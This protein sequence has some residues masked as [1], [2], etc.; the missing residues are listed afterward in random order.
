M[1]YTTESSTGPTT[2]PHDRSPVV[3]QRQ[4]SPPV[5]RAHCNT[6]PTA[7]VPAS[8]TGSA[9]L[10]GT[11]LWSRQTLTSPTQSLFSDGFA[12]VA[13][14]LLLSRSIRDTTVHRTEGGFS[15]SASNYAPSGD[16]TD[17]GHIAASPADIPELLICDAGGAGNLSGR[18]ATTSSPRLAS[19]SASSPACSAEGRTVMNFE[20]LWNSIDR[21]LFAVYTTLQTGDESS[22]RP[23]RTPRHRMG[24]YTV[25]Y[26]ACSG[27]P[28]KSRELYA[29]LA[30]L[31]LH[32]LESHVLF[33]IL[34]N[35]DHGRIHVL[36]GTEDN[37]VATTSTFAEDVVDASLRLS[38]SWNGSST[39]QQSVQAPQ[40]GSGSGSGGSFSGWNRLRN[41]AAGTSSSGGGGGRGGAF[42]G[43]HP[44]V[45][46]S[47]DTSRNS[48][49]HGSA[50]GR[51]TT[52]VVPHTSA[53]NSSFGFM[54]R[55]FQPSHRAT[56]PVASAHNDNDVS[57]DGRIREVGHQSSSPGLPLTS[58]SLSVA[59][60]PPRGRAGWSS[61]SA[62]STPLQLQT[63]ASSDSAG[64]FTA[65]QSR[66]TATANELRSAFEG[67]D[68][69]VCRSSGSSSATASGSAATMRM[70]L[71]INTDLSSSTPVEVEEMPL[72]Q[73]RPIPQSLLSPK[74]TTRSV[75]HTASGTSSTFSQSPATDP[76]VT[77]VT[78][79]TSAAAATHHARVASKTGRVLVNDEEEV[80]C[81][82]NTV[83]S[84]VRHSRRAQQP[85]SK[86]PPAAAPA[87][88][89]TAV[90]GESEKAV[91]RSPPPLPS[92]D[93]STFTHHSSSNDED[94]S[95]HTM[96]SS[97][98]SP[99]HS[100]DDDDAGGDSS[101]SAQTSSGPTMI[102]REQRRA[103]RTVGRRSPPPPHRRGVVS[104]AVDD[105]TEDSTAVPSANLVSSPSTS[106]TS[107]EDIG[108]PFLSMSP[109]I[110][111]SPATTGA[112]EHKNAVATSITTAPPDPSL[113]LSESAPAADEETRML[114]RILHSAHAVNSLPMKRVGSASAVA[115]PTA[116]PVDSAS[117][118]SLQPSLSRHTSS[119]VPGSCFTGRETAVPRTS[120]TTMQDLDSPQ[121]SPL[122]YG[123]RGYSGGHCAGDK[124][125]ATSD[126]A[127][128]SIHVNRRFSLCYTFIQEWETFLVF[129]GVV[130][131]CFR[132]LDQYYTRRYGMDTITLMCFKVFYV[133]VYEPLRPLLALE[134]R[135]LTRYVRE[136][137]ETTRQIAWEQL[138]LIQTTYNIMAELLVLV[139]STSSYMVSQKQQK[140]GSGGVGGATVTNTA[141]SAAA[142]AA[143]SQQALHSAAEPPRSRTNSRGRGLISGSGG[144]V[145]SS[146]SSVAST[147]RLGPFEAAMGVSSSTAP[148]TPA[149]GSHAAGTE[150]Q[151]ATTHTPSRRH[152]LL[153]LFTSKRHSD[154]PVSAKEE[155]RA[156]PQQQQQQQQ[157]K[158][159]GSRRGAGI[160]PSAFA[161][162]RP[163][164]S[165]M[166]PLGGQGSGGGAGVDGNNSHCNSSI[167]NARLPTTD[168]A[169]D[170]GRVD[171][172]S[173]AM[174]SPVLAGSSPGS[175]IMP[176]TVVVDL[177][178]AVELRD[179]LEGHTTA[180]HL[181]TQALKQWEGLAADRRLRNGTIV[182][183]TAQ[184]LA[185][186]VMEDMGND[187]VAGVYSFYRCA[188]EAHRD[189][190][191]GRRC[192]VEWALGVKELE[193]HVWRRVRLP[194][195]HMAIRSAL[196]EVLVV[197]QHRSILLDH[198][199]GLGTLL[200]EWSASVKNDDL[201]L[202][203]QPSML[204]GAASAVAAVWRGTGGDTSAAA[205]PMLL[206]RNRGSGNPVPSASPPASLSLSKAA[207]EF[208]EDPIQ[209]GLHNA[210]RHFVSCF[211][212]SR[213][214]TSASF[215][216]LS[217][218][219]SSQ[220]MLTTGG[221]SGDTTT[222]QHQ[223][224]SRR[225]ERASGASVVINPTTAAASAA[226]TTL[227][228]LSRVGACGGAGETSESEDTSAGVPATTAGTAAT[229]IAASQ[230]RDLVVRETTR[231]RAVGGGD[232]QAQP[233][234]RHDSAMTPNTAQL[235]AGPVVPT[236]H[237]AVEALQ[238]LYSL[239]SDVTEDE[240]FV[241]MASILITNFIRAA[242]DSFE[243]YL[244]KTTATMAVDEPGSSS[245]REAAATSSPPASS[246]SRPPNGPA[247]PAA[248]TLAGS[249]V[250]LM[251]DLI[252]LIDRY[253][254]LVETAFRSQPILLRALGDA[255]EELMCPTRWTKKGSL[256]AAQQRA[257]EMLMAA[258]AAAAVNS[259][260]NVGAATAA[261]AAA[262]SSKSDL[263]SV[264]LSRD[265][266]YATLPLVS[267]ATR[268]PQAVHQL[269]LSVLLAR[270]AD[271]FLQ[272]ERVGGR[273][274]NG[275]IFKRL[276][277]IG[278]LVSLLEDKDTFLEHYRLCLA[279]RLLGTSGSVAPGHEAGSPTTSGGGVGSGSGGGLLN[280]EA[281][282]QL[283]GCLQSYLGAT[284]TH[285]FEAML[286][287]YEGTQRTRE[288]FEQEPTFEAL[289]AKI[290]VQLITSAQWPMYTMLPL[291][292]HSS[293]QIGM[294]AFRGY[295][296]RVHPSRTLL[297]VFSLGTAT[298][299]AE[300]VSGTKQVVAST[301][302][303]TLLLVVSDAYNARAGHAGSITGSQIA[304]KVGMPFHALRTHLHLLSQH[305]AFNLL[306]WTPV[307][308]TSVVDAA[309][310]AGSSAVTMTENDR[311]TLNPAYTHKLRK[312][313]L[314]LPKTRL[315]G[316]PSSEAQ[317]DHAMSSM[318]DGAD[319]TAVP[320]SEDVV[321]SRHVHASRRQLL[322]T[323]LV[324]VFKSRRVVLFED[325]FQA[326]TMQL[327]RQF[328]PTRRDVKA[329]LEGLI[330]RDYVKRSADD[331]NAFVYVS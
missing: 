78:A 229:R 23:L 322:D 330:D 73:D 162:R 48:S 101:R 34:Q 326:V 105:D 4:R 174:S 287:D 58:V 5:C 289:V 125:A 129:R 182:K 252:L 52:A 143:L 234:P 187:Y 202:T 146:A 166:S 305:R 106:L 297:W 88:V 82:E 9:R 96:N 312:I 214:A 87:A 246:S 104:T 238:A 84:T 25:I 178:G 16:D 71:K 110:T 299:T 186:I 315:T 109:T 11:P 100:H 227:A 41:I 36:T 132:Y 320:E 159:S 209:V 26:N 155:V 29:R 103:G 112:P 228:V 316:L 141:S 142:A 307:K 98:P 161:N 53:G 311:F 51:N 240:C 17:D 156:A 264:L 38:R 65:Y 14:P 168:D 309:T 62:P 226:S 277:L 28:A 95:L 76:H 196:N 270:Y 90:V 276:R 63:R 212:H 138:E 306:R 230:R 232:E 10:T 39:S 61:T 265:A 134:L 130:L 225:W 7:T 260:D 99:H 267:L 247:A 149:S 80:L 258:A 291:T 97:L 3:R 194:F 191:E 236:Q 144:G 163:S 204:A 92:A 279:R 108:S 273:V 245:G 94:A 244:L 254:E 193:T 181:T 74:S 165:R 18:T 170:V 136:V 304:Q 81:E 319:G 121:K 251:T 27:D 117:Q 271:A 257:Q 284:G 175:P 44:R 169:L 185:T 189:T 239:F 119:S 85:P 24:W 160:R 286:R 243:A 66:K 20:S 253:T 224:S 262:A 294:D 323:A 2:E 176:S 281:E 6:V 137:F 56:S 140:P 192:Y 47:K 197:E 298:L 111:T 113:S 167:S 93:T 151:S 220:L 35:V 12:S 46:L 272:Q 157:S 147:P 295:Y 42:F 290:R 183:E 102:G 308:P 255:I 57:D 216:Q 89:T 280:L 195:L 285:A 22:L 324:R 21:Y 301:L 210:D 317:A 241:L 218:Q 8:S 259:S 208:V 222:T 164:P 91:N 123:S 152:R 86:T 115:T 139:Q 122:Y 223:E 148:T 49:F 198:Q 32:L 188:S 325:L 116:S 314:P 248:A 45:G 249:G 233:Q 292:P 153:S 77:V 310:T 302:L 69:T 221:A 201:A 67:F 180:H 177:R 171:V 328:V 268:H 213:S 13:A 217:R 190:E 50:S 126:H 274:V 250:Q 266:R 293:L 199:F 79:T 278:R 231:T 300:V 205:A 72:S 313:R 256:Q 283:V 40:N 19:P 107:V 127:G 235:P 33:P 70:G 303:A 31:L 184:P 203:P 207:S 75:S 59:R 114:P 242:A 54:L 135:Y 1:Q 261:T 331:P 282:R 60:Q 128:S 321:V 15:R 68:S 83:P 219:G 124:T 173:G 133:T 327:A 211:P 154:T 296:A 118:I 200:D 55:L 237:P 263:P 179:R 43:G 269:K 172:V 158:S 37:V 288:L 30:L 329:Q 206:G 64:A 120:Y 131:S 215:D 318:A 150:E 275:G 145:D